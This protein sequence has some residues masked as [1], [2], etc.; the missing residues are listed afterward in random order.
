V[1]PSSGRAGRGQA[2]NRRYWDRTS[3]DYQREHATELEA[4]P[5]AWG[6]G[7]TPERRVRALGHRSLAGA[8]VVDLGCGGGHWARAL[9]ARGARVAALDLSFAQLRHARRQGRPGGP[10]PALVHADG[11]RLPLADRSVDVVLS[12]HGALGFVDPEPAL[13]ELARVLRPG[14][15]LAFCVGSPLRH[16]CSDEDW[17]VGPRLHRPLFGPTVIDDGEVVEHVLRHGQWLAL[18]RAAG[19]TVVALH[20]LQAP[21]RGTSSFEWFAPAAWARRWPAEDLWVADRDR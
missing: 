15:R 5:E 8:T 16:A 6:T 14:G 7:R 18:L 19:F 4:A 10:G 2:V 21:A 3:A 11:E 13:A 12:D 1:R 20:E 17:V 9:A